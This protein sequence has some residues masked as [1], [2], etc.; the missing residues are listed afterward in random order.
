MSIVSYAL[1]YINQNGLLW[2]ILLLFANQKSIVIS[3]SKLENI[4][5]M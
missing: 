3:A 2:K 1:K 5:Q 4:N